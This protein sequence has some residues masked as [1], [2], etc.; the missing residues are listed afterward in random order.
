MRFKS[1]VVLKKQDKKRNS[2]LSLVIELIIWSA[3]LNVGT[4]WMLRSLSLFIGSKELVHTFE[5]VLFLYMLKQVCFFLEHDFESF[6]PTVMSSFS[7][8]SEGRH[9]DCLVFA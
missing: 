4:K 3:D 9:L 2:S 6:T 8:N 5:I 1:K 7:T